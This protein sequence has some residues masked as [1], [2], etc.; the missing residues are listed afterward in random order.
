[1]KR[2]IRYK[3]SK[4]SA[5]MSVVVGVVFVIIGLTMV[6]PGTFSSGFLP[7]ALFGLLWTGLAAATAVVNALY[8]MG[9]RD[10]TNLYGGY[11][12]TDEDPAE[13]PAFRA[14]A[15][16]HQH[17]TPSG[18]DAKARLEQLESLKEAGLL[19]QEEYDQKRREILKGL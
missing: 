11:E 18:L 19:T 13:S 5:A 6:I 14:D 3:P 4:L 10:N 2:N 1:M 8:L 7:V 12:I 17:I 9:K 16:D 15:P